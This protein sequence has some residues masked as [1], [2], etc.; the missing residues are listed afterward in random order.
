MCNQSS[1]IKLMVDDGECNR[2]ICVLDGVQDKRIASLMVEIGAKNSEIEAVRFL[3]F[4]ILP[5]LTS[6]LSPIC[7][8]MLYMSHLQLRRQL[9]ESQQRGVEQEEALEA[10]RAE[11]NADRAAAAAE[12]GK[13]DD[14]I[15]GGQID[16]SFCVCM[17]VCVVIASVRFCFPEIDAEC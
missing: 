7:N 17:Y 13:L 12:I 8:N 15:K 5:F 4:V 6:F 9:S 11:L 10:A 3:S 16:I 1:V 2:M 14:D